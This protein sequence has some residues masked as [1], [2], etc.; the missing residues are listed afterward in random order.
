M[1][2][3]WKDIAGF[4]GRY[5]ISDQG[6]VKALSFMQRWRH[7]LRRVRERILSQQGIN[8]GYQIVHLYLDNV[9]VARTVHRL[10]AFAFCPGADPKLDVNHID[11]NK[12]NNAASNLEWL[13]RTENHDHA[14][15]LGLNT[16][17]IRVRGV[18]VAGGPVVEYPSMAQAAL[19][20][21]GRRS[22]SAVSACIRGV[23]RTA[24]GYPWS[25]ICD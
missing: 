11:G 14:V 10:V 25:T 7:G 21:A 17:A 23:Q 12:K 2:E 16:A 9:G 3:Q 20:L 1:T 19:Q 4:E 6:R 8:S 18:P 15:R 5:Q 24:Y 22:A 13:G